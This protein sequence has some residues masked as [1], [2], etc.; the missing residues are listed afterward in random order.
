MCDLPLIQW[1]NSMEV[2]EDHEKVDGKTVLLHDK[3]MSPST[4]S[5]YSPIHWLLW[6]IQW[7]LICYNLQESCYRM[8]PR[9]GATSPGTTR[10]Q[11]G[12]FFASSD[13]TTAIY[14]G[15]EN[16]D[17]F[18]G[19]VLNDLTNSH[20]CWISPQCPNCFP[21][22]Y[23]WSDTPHGGAPNR[24]SGENFSGL[25]NP[26]TIP[27][28]SHSL[29]RKLPHIFRDVWVLASAGASVLVLFPRRSCSSLCSFT[30]PSELREEY[31]LHGW[32]FI[33]A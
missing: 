16:G 33:I 27:V 24:C 15:Y 23:P 3:N 20:P 2:L 10:S 7:L 31:R 32:F 26:L 8:I 25:Q 9:P 21:V 30:Y 14:S 5:L 29:P 22:E 19:G 17:F 28:C 6:S 13:V 4:S 1:P 12:D 18:F 11:S